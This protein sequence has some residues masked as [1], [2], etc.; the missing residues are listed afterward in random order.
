MKRRFIGLLLALSCLQSLSAQEF[1]KDGSVLYSIG[2]GYERMPDAYSPQGFSLGVS[3]RF[4]TSGRMFCELMGHWGTHEGD[5][6]VMQKGKPFAVHDER[7]CLLAAAGAGYDV[8]QD[9]GKRYALYVKALAGYG[10]RSSR[11]DDYMPSDADDG[12]VTLGCEDNRK[13]LAFVAG[14][15]FDA[16][17]GRWTLTPSVD[18]IFVGGRWN[19]APMLSFGFFY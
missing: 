12:S 14:V 17:F 6:T 10:V 9:A 4:Y 1:S 3:V 11:Y 5:K 8:F 19:V 13:G 16:R 15:G 18:A 7:D 2:A